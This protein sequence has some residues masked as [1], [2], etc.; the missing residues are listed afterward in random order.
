VNARLSAASS[1]NSRH[2]RVGHLFQ[3]RFKSLLVDADEYL[4]ETVTWGLSGPASPSQTQ[5]NR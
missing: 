4:L 5:T 1:F 2:R 3:K